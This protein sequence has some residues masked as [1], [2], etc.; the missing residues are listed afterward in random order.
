MKKMLL[1][2]FVAL[3]VADVV[4]FAVGGP[5]PKTPALWCS[6]AHAASGIDPLK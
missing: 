1:L 6:G 2:V 3:V 5:T 4:P